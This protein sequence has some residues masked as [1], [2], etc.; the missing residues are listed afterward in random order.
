MNGVSRK[1]RSNSSRRRAQSS[2]SSNVRQRYPTSSPSV[3]SGPACAL[4]ARASSTISSLS[5]VVSESASILAARNP[6]DLAWSTSPLVMRIV[7]SSGLG[8]WYIVRYG[9]TCC[10]ACA[11][12]SFQTGSPSTL[13]ARSQSAMSTPAKAMR[14]SP[15]RADH[16]VP[17]QS[18]SHRRR[19]SRG[20]W[21]TRMSETPR[22]HEND[23]GSSMSVWTSTCGSEN[24]Q[25]P[26]ASHANPA[27]Q[28]TISSAQV[29]RRTR[30]T[31]CRSMDG[32]PIKGE[33]GCDPGQATKRH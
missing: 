7:S 31:V 19:G 8:P 27:S 20:S 33:G 21:P 10:G 12:R 26:P 1:K 5:S 3:N 16:T 29:G 32:R 9:I 6:S 11:P 22:L 28:A 2:A 25:V 30:S 14:P 18:S 4:T 24:N 13:P 17:S 23:V 15:T